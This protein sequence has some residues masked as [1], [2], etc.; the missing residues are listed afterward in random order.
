MVAVAAE[1]ERTISLFT[2]NQQKLELLKVI[3][4]LHSTRIIRLEITNDL[5]MS[6]AEEGD[7]E[8]KAR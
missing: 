8:V 1:F 6:C 2:R 4:K 7:T 3:G 5:L